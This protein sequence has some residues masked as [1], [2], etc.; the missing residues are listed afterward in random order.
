[1][2][3]LMLWCRDVS[4]DSGPAPNSPSP[5]KNTH[6]HL[7]QPQVAGYGRVRQ[8]RQQR[9]QHAGALQDVLV[10]WGEAGGGGMSECSFCLAG[11]AAAAAVALS[12]PPFCW[13]R[14]PD[15]QSAAPPLLTKLGRRQHLQRLSHVPPRRRRHAPAVRGQQRHQLPRK[16]GLD[17]AVGRR[18]GRADALEQQR[19][20]SLRAGRGD[21][22]RATGSQ[23]AGGAGDDG[24]AVGEGG[25]WIPLVFNH[26]QQRQLHL[27]KNHSGPNLKDLE[28]CAHAPC[29]L[30]VP[31]PVA[32][33]AP[34]PGT[35]CTIHS[36][37]CSPLC[38]ASQSPCSASCG[39]RPATLAMSWRDGMREGGEGVT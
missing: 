24:C 4:D 29:R 7:Q 3:G 5:Q 16:L 35:R 32:S 27:N 21:G 39:S 18:L 20:R 31:R 13:R 8:R 37:S 14:P 26:Q 6:S 12:P 10:D 30:P 25:G 28:H 11:T 34:L 36:S 22:R 19:E 23:G 2:V 17:H 38:S 9:V 33:A 1:M 15:Q